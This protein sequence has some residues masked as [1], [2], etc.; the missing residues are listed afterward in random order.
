[1]DTQQILQYMA[2]TSDDQTIYVSATRLNGEGGIIKWDTAGTTATE[3]DI[4]STANLDTVYLLS[5][6]EVLTIDRPSADP[7][8]RFRKLDFS[9]VTVSWGH[10]MDCPDTNGCD[11]YISSA[12]HDSGKIYTWAGMGKP[13]YGYRLIFSTLNE[14]DGS[15]IGNVFESQS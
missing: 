13:T 15:L 12:V 3:Y 5:N 8:Q 1:M 11:S 9:T 10:L 2:I 14:T 7:K 4:G 6:T